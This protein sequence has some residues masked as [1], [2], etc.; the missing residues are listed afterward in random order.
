[1]P[2][3]PAHKPLEEYPDRWLEFKP[4]GSGGSGRQRLAPAAKVGTDGIMVL[5]HAASELL[6]N[7]AR[8]LVGVNPFQ[9]KFRLK[10]TTPDDAGGFAL[11]GGGN[12]QS[13]ISIKEII[14]KYPL[15]AGTYRVGKAA[16]GIMLVWE[17]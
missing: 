3:K 7:P 1:M 12:A 15:L 6:G 2:T 8:V 10:P 13:R 11:S 14:N 5:N 9:R 4:G 16:S 17:E